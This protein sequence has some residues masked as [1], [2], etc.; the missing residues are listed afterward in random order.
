MTNI[1]GYAN[2]AATMAAI[3]RLDDGTYYAEV[4]GLPGV[5]AN[6]NTK[7]ACLEELRSVIAGW[8]TIREE[9]NLTI[10]DL[11]MVEQQWYPSKQRSVER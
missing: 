9:R 4:K 1:K 10:P 2:K 7:K 6:A 5:W 11:D 8:V 3:E